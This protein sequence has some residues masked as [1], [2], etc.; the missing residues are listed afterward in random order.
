MH[1]PTTLQSLIA[2]RWLGSEAHQPLHS[3]LDNQLIYHTHADK[4]DFGEAVAYA[5]KTGVQALMQMDF[6]KR[7]QRLKALAAYLM[8][9]KEELYEISHLTGATRPDSWV[10]VE[11]GIGTLYAYASIG[12]RELPSSNVLHEGPAMALG[13]RG[14]FAGTH[15][16]VPRGGVAV[17]INAFNFPIWGL[18]EKF[19][20]SFLAAMPCIAK[21]ATATSYLTHAVVKMMM[22]SGL[23]PEGCLQLVIGSTGD[24]LDRLNGFDAVT[25]TGS[26]DT[27][28]KLRGNTN[29]IRESVPFTAEADSLNAAILAPDVTPDDEELDL[30]VK[31]VARE[32]TGKAGQKC[33]AIRRVIVPEHLADVVGAR[34]RARLAKIVV[35]NPKVEGVRMG[36]LASLDQHRDVSERVEMLARGNEVLFS[37]RDGFQPVGDGVAA[38]AFFA[39]TLLLCRNAMVNDAVHD[40]EAFGPVSTMMT[41]RDIDEALAL[42]ARGKGSLVTTLVTK[43]PAIAAHAVPVA[44]ASHGRVHILDRVA[45]V[46]STGHGSPLPMLKHGGPG[47]AGGGEE[48]GGIRAVKH[49]LQRAAVQGSPTMLAAVTGEYVR[50]AAVKESDVHPFRRYFEDLEIGHSLLTHRRTVSEADIVNFGGVSGDYFY[51]HFDEIAAK[52]TQFGKRIAHGYFVLS[53]AAGLF[54]SPAPGPVLANYGLDNLRFVAPVAIGDTIRA[55]LTCKRK[56]DRNRTD[57]QG[58]GQGVVAWDVQVTNQNDELVASYDILTLVQKRG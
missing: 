57:D 36:A 40:I 23:L 5:R 58:R 8:E 1:T 18:L 49:F 43:D 9:R 20:P 44:A 32:M 34:L 33:T 25:F 41:Y 17:H 21:P 11:G 16:L 30:F 42:A 39:P 56:V 28:A 14:G 48:L 26:A 22:E 53:A 38:G 24:L 51:M 7:A 10:D 47:R 29:L 46:D 45:A 50:G 52:D 6:Q 12:G 13:K 15:I 35:G 31:E 4:I 27:A 2:G 55:R 3:A 19:A 54:V 37:A